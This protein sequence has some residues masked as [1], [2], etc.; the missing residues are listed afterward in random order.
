MLLPT[1]NCTVRML[2]LSCVSTLR[3][4]VCLHFQTVHCQHPSLQADPMFCWCQCPSPQWCGRTHHPNHHVFGMDYDAPCRHPLAWNGQVQL[5]PMAVN[6]AA[7]LFN[8]MPNPSSGLSPHDLCSCSHW[9]QDKVHDCHAWGCPVYV[10]EKAMVDGKKLPHWKPHSHCGIYVGLSPHHSSSVSLVLNLPLVSSLPSSI[11]VSI[12]GFQPLPLPWRTCQI[13]CV[14][15]ENACLV[16]VC[17]SLSPN[18]MMCSP[19]P[20]EDPSDVDVTAIHDQSAPPASPTLCQLHC[21]ISLLKLHPLPCPL[22][23][24]Q[25]PLLQLL[26]VTSVLCPLQHICRGRFPLHGVAPPL[27]GSPHLRGRLPF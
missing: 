10:L 23:P 7:Y 16:T 15:H 27:K 8:H 20:T 26:T 13:L 14:M 21:P 25:P 2:G 6:C 9:E 22:P 3:Q 19:L 18:H 17:T 1:M 11:L 24:P 12:I 4:W 5:W